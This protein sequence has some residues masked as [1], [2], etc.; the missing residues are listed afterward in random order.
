[1]CPSC[2]PLKLNPWSCHPL[3]S[4]AGL[5]AQPPPLSFCFFFIMSYQTDAP[6]C[7][8]FC[9]HSNWSRVSRPSDKLYIIWWREKDKLGDNDLYLPEFYSKTLLT[10]TV[11]YKW[12]HN[13]TF[14]NTDGEMNHLHLNLL[15]HTIHKHKATSLRTHLILNGMFD[16]ISTLTAM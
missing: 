11:L 9:L 13:S 1:M 5:N 6:V 2:P 16:L 14:L 15:K 3:T 8:C 4:P 7:L 12:E 10:E